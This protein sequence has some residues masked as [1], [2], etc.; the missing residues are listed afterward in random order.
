VRSRTVHVAD[1]ARTVCSKVVNYVKD[2][3]MNVGETVFDKVRYRLRPGTVR[4]APA[5]QNLA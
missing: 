4:F 3:A 5:E 1:V 2:G